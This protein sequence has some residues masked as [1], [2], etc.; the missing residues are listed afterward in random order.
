MINEKNAKERGRPID[1]DNL[2]GQAQLA[3]PEVDGKAFVFFAIRRLSCISKLGSQ[4][5]S[6]TSAEVKGS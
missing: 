3:G 2:P 4:K 6:A 5:P 1:F